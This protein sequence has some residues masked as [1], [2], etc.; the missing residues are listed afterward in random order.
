[1]TGIAARPRRA[2][3]PA[4]RLRG[5]ADHAGE[6]RSTWTELFFDLVFVV[7][8]AQLAAGLHRDPT[9]ATAGAFLGLFVPVAWTWTTYAYLGDLFDSGERVFRW[10]LLAAMFLVAV[11]AAAIPDAFAGRSD[12]FVVAYALLRLDV[13]AVYLWAWRT[14]AGVRTLAGKHAAGLGLGLVVWSSSL[15]LDEPLRYGVWAL[16][17]ACDLGTGLFVYS[18]RAAVPRHHSH[19]P[20]RFGLFTL[21]VLGESIVAVSSGTAHDRWTSGSLAAAASAFVLAACLWW[22]YFARFDGEVFNW[23]LGGSGPERV[24]SYVYGYAHLLLFP[25]TAAIGVGAELAITA[26][27]GAAGASAAAPVM[28]GGVAAYLLSVS[29]IQ[30][31]A[32][33]GLGRGAVAPRAAVAVAASALAILGARLGAVLTPALLA[34]ALVVDVAL[35]GRA[36]GPDPGS[37]AGGGTRTPTVCTTRT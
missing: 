34:G 19:M 11:L 33:A 25:A 17:I 10:I 20:E 23:A 22:L 37:D 5:S 18:G 3:R 14:D 26:A 27:N 31:A 1:M 32:P 15:A 2:E 35:E 16:A 29:A 21:I 7:A 12:R 4:L 28:G 9:I 13:V 8:V 36:P 24:R 30:S 6:R